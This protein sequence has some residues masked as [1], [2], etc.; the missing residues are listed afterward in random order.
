MFAAVEAAERGFVAPAVGVPFAFG[1]GNYSYSLNYT[2]MGT[3]AQAQADAHTHTHTDARVKGRKE[4]D[5]PRVDVVYDFKHQGDDALGK[6][7]TV[8]VRVNAGRNKRSWYSTGVKCLPCQWMEGFGVVGRPD[9]AEMNDKIKA[10]YE[11]TKEVVTAEVIDAISQGHPACSVDI[12][13]KMT[14]KKTGSATFLDFM[15]KGIDEDDVG[16]QTKSQN[17]AQLAK[18]EEWGRMK[19]F[20]DVSPDRV[21]EFFAWCRQ[22]TVMKKVNGK[23]VPVPI[24]ETTVANAAKAV[25]KFVKKAQ[26]KGHIGPR[27]IMGVE[28]PTVQESDRVAMSDDEVNA[29]L[30]F[31]SPLPHLCNARDRYIVQMATGVDYSTL[32]DVDWSQREMIDGKMTLRGTRVKGRDSHRVRGKKKFFLV[33]L[34]MAW[35][36]LERW[37]WKIP[38]ITNQKYNEYLLK[39]E[40]LLEL[41]KHVTSHVA[42]HTYACLCLRHGIRIEAVQRMLGHTRL[43]TTQIYAKMVNQDVLN[44]FDDFKETNNIKAK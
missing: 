1:G 43:Q 23:V 22:K 29:W 15:R 42:R 38:P 18:L 32:M 37:D 30:N 31:D 21:R 14:K 20:E 28:W 4:G 11:H 40:T 39:I 10:Y 2:H 44:A 36:I 6:E 26:A 17:R 12:K 19:R 25:R 13:A 27:A 24:S 16:E 33:I 7:G 5:A 3:Q 41:K 34:P 9:A 8:W 35:E